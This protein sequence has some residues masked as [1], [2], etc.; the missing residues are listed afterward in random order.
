MKDKRGLP[1]H[2]LSFNHLN[3]QTVTEF[4]DWLQEERKYSAATRNQRLMALRSFI[5]FAAKTDSSKISLQIELKNVDTQKASAKIVEF[6][7]EDALKTL[8]AQP[9]RH[10]PKG[11]RNSFFMALMYD[12]AAR[13]QEVLDLR[14]KDFELSDHKPY[15]YLTGKGDKIRSVPL[16]DKTIE[17]FK[18]YIDMFHPAA[19]RKNDDL[20]FYTIIH[21]RKNQMSQDNVGS[22][23][24]KYGK[25]AKLCCPSV[26]DKV[27]A[28][29]LR[30]T[31]AIHLYRSGYPM[32]LLSELLGH[33]R[34]T[35]TKIYAYAD[36]E[37]KRAAI[38]KADPNNDAVQDPA[39]WEGDDDMIKQLYG[40][41]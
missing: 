10:K 18:F 5:K 16:M 28:H 31:R 8:L 38:R 2:K 9:D 15:V 11:V 25:S 35:T 7:S 19:T 30:H 17:H 41:K 22:F 21:G 37:M 12:T 3:Y 6:L 24:K 33:V 29:Q 39:M 27:H 36:T 23:L 4:L 26:P 1:M 40:L 14:L 20:L 34:M 13:C 32:A